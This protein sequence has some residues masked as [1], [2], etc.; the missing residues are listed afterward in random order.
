MIMIKRASVVI[1]GG[2]IIGCSIAYNLAKMGCR[3][4]VLSEK[5]S[6]ASGAIGRCGSG[7]RQQFGTIMNCSLARENIKIFENFI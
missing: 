1:I 3:N 7:I 2:G 6:L 5:N 4:V